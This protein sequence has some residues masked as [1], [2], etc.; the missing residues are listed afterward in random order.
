MVGCLSDEYSRLFAF[1]GTRED[2]H[3][4]EHTVYKLEIPGGAL[5][6]A[7]QH[8]KQ[9][10]PATAIPGELIRQLEAEL[11][12]ALGPVARVFVRRA[13]LS[14]A[15][16][17]ELIQH[18]A[19]ELPEAEVRSAFLAR[20]HGKPET[21]SPGAQNLPPRSGA[22]RPRRDTDATTSLEELLAEYVG[23]LSRILVKR[24]AAKAAT[25][26]EL[27][28]LLKAEIPDP[29]EQAAFCRRG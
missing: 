20:H 10:L 11:S 28:N 2:K 25:A 5:V 6:R 4:R 16:P 1:G 17:A 19:Q 24:A 15:H 29:R 9:S 26:S 18:I 14:A 8:T 22:S 7:P 13:A 3:T 21:T 23:P 12:E 27:I